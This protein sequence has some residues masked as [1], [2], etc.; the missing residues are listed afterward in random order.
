MLYCHRS[1]LCSVTCFII[2]YENTHAA[3]CIK[4][5]AVV[6][7]IQLPRCHSFSF[8]QAFAETCNSVCSVCPCMCLCLIV[9]ADKL[10]R[11]GAIALQSFQS[12]NFVEPFRDWSRQDTNPKKACE[13]FTRMASRVFFHRAKSNSPSCSSRPWGKSSTKWP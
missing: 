9:S 6:F 7:C 3:F 5:E 12:R 2:F 11:L 4:L 1:Q 8:P 10:R 13:L